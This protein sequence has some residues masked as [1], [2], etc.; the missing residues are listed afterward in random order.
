[1]AKVQRA[2]SAILV[3][4]LLMFI[5]AGLFKL[6]SAAVNF[7]HSEFFT[8]GTEGFVNAIFL[9]VYSVTGYWMNINYASDAKNP[10]KDVPWSIIMVVPIIMIITTIMNIIMIT[11]ITTMNIITMFIV[12][13]SMLIKLL[14]IVGLMKELKH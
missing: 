13:Y 12:I 3:L 10:K 4:C 11:N 1:M 2:M 7:A 9:Y 6:D 8:G 5:V 14:M